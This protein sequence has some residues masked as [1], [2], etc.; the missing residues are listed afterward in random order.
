MSD[1]H[2]KRINKLRELMKK[3]S[4]DYYIVP[5]SDP[6]MS[7]YI[8]EH[9]K[10]REYLTGFT[11]SAGTLLV[12]MQRAFLWTD[13]RYY[14][15]AEEELKG[16]EIEL[17]RMQDEGVPSLFQFLYDNAFDKFIGFDGSVMSQSYYDDICEVVEEEERIRSDLTYYEEIWEERPLRESKETLHLDL[18]ISGKKSLKKIEEL[19]AVLYDYDAEGIMLT[20]LSDI[21]WLFNIRGNDIIY[22]P[23]AYS[24]AFISRNKILL[25]IDGLKKEESA[26]FMEIARLQVFPYAGL[27]EEMEKLKGLKII[28][29]PDLINTRLYSCLLENNTLLEADH[30]LFIN[31]AVKNEREIELSK[32]YHF[33]DG[34][35][36]IR[37]I[38]DIKSTVQ[39]RAVSEYEAALLVDEYRAGTEGFIEASFETI[40]AYGENGAIVHYSPHKDKSAILKP[41]GFVLLD[42]GGQYLGATTDIT[43][44]VALGRL[45]PDMKEAYTA[46]LKGHLRLMSLVFLKGCRGENLDIAARE[47]LWQLYL[48]YKHGTGHG[49][50]SFLNVHE[51]PQAFRYKIL[52]EHIQPPLEAGMI[53]SDEPGI[54]LRGKFGIRIENLLLCINKAQNEW[55]TF[56]GFESL[57]LVPFEREAILKEKLTFEEKKVLND[58]HKMVYECYKDYLDNNDRDLKEWLKKETEAIN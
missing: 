58:Y 27:Y 19:L 43:R 17:M 18:D 39:K 57:S 34:L 45:T 44:T 53:T 49:V 54:Y 29:D 32:K 23:L 24:Y 50:G 11:G 5:T 56:L 7:E 41:E 33:Y 16:S 10:F 46:V 9:Y 20:E 2:K 8:G 55:G 52:E 25:F 12:G 35:S 21:M 51:G 1:I 30:T 48:D 42:S 13:G 4:L 6:H 15:Q 40:C 47:P 36:V 26:E 37:W 28:V 14:L 31:K 3:D 38:R 22:N